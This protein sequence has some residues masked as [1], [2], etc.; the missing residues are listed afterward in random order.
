MKCF[1]VD[2]DGTLVRTN[3]L[4]Y[5]EAIRRLAFSSHRSFENLFY[6]LSFWLALPLIL[7][8]HVT[9]KEHLR[10]RLTYFFYRGLPESKIYEYAR[11]FWRKNANK[12]NRNVIS[13]IRK[14]MRA[15]DRVVSLAVDKS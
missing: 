2:W 12:I 6:F 9:K 1:F 5:V 7:I 11:V 10:D 14:L 3:S 8:L 4:V 13:E 15:E